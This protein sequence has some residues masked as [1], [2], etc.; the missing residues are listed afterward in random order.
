MGAINQPLRFIRKVR[1][2]MFRVWQHTTN[3][4]YNRSGRKERCM[5]ALASSSNEP[6]EKPRLGALVALFFAPAFIFANMYTTQ[7]ILPVLSHDFGI[8][9]PT[10]GLTV[11]LLV[12]A[13]AIGSLFYGPL[14]DRVGRKPVMD[15]TS[16]LV[17]IPTL[18]CGLAPNFAI[19]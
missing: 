10:A 9:A 7:A 19:L 13:V 11:S 16:F 6:Q 1:E 8:S 14:S 18:L 2:P 17:T 15:G 4:E 3:G 12:L 5:S